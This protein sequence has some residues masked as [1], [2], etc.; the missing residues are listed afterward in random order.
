MQRY[1]ISQ[2]AYIIGVR[3]ITV[4]DSNGDYI[5]YSDHIAEVQRL[6]GALEMI[7]Y[8]FWQQWKEPIEEMRKIAKEALD[9][10]R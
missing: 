7:N 3:G 10:T 1:K 6:K 5:L 8:P 2:V 4:P 9:E